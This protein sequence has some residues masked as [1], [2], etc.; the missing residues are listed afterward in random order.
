M[1]FTK[2]SFSAID[3]CTSASCSF[4]FTSQSAISFPRYASA[5]SGLM[6]R[7]RSQYSFASSHLPS[8][9][10]KNTRFKS[11]SVFALPELMTTVCFAAS[12]G[13]SLPA[14]FLMPR[15]K[16]CMKPSLLISCACR[17]ENSSGKSYGS[18]SRYAGISI[19]FA[20]FRMSARYLLHSFFTHTALK[21]SGFVPITTMT[22]AE[23]KAANMYGS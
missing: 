7:T 4:L 15:I 21:Y 16:S 5:H 18:I 10:N 1:V 19:F 8:S 14:I 22:F 9:R 13:A 23:F 17:C 3:S 6:S 20:L 12:F 2:L 11:P